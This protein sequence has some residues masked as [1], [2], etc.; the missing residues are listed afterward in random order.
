MPAQMAMILGI[1]RKGISCSNRKRH[2]WQMYLVQAFDCCRRNLVSIQGSDLN[3]IPS[4]TSGILSCQRVQTASLIS[5][6]IP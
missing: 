1:L 6:F 3:T 2:A 5:D 4:F